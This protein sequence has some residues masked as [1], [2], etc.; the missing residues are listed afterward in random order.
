MIF[1]T[2][3]THGIY[4]KPHIAKF[5]P[6]CE[7]HPN[8]TRDDYVIVCGDFL[9]MLSEENAVENFLKF[10]EKYP[11]TVLFVD[12]NHENFDYLESV[13]L[14][15]RFGGKV[16]VLGENVIHLPRGQ[17]L[18][19]DGKKFFAF[20]GATSADKETRL[21]DKIKTWWEREVPTEEDYLEGIKNLEK[22]NFTV[23]HILTHTCPEYAFYDWKFKRATF[24][25]MFP[26]LIENSML[27]NIKEMTTYKHWFFGH[28]HVDVELSVFP[29]TAVLLDFI[30][31]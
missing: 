26:T 28:F 23:D 16:R 19:I 30:E 25:Q 15:E 8:L 17:V 12:G 6:F 13:P 21:R 1:V 5:E 9:G 2:G 27:S 10:Y 24:N 7:S 11:F 14:T 20:G 18:E 22:H 3:D 29:A 31:I 4:Y